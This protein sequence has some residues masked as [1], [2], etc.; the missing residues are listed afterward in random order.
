MISLDSELR[1][2]ASLRSIQRY[3]L[4]SLVRYK[5]IK[6]ARLRTES[7]ELI[8]QRSNTNERRRLLKTLNH[9]KRFDS[10]EHHGI[11]A[12][13]VKTHQPYAMEKNCEHR[14]LTSSS[15]SLTIVGSDVATRDLHR[16]VNVDSFTFL[17]PKDLNV[18]LSLK[19]ASSNKLHADHTIAPLSPRSIA[20]A[21]ALKL[22]QGVND[23][24][25]NKMENHKE[26]LFHYGIAR[27]QRNEDCR[28]VAHRVSDSF[29]DEKNRRYQ[30][31]R[32]RVFNEM[33]LLHDRR[34]M[35]ESMMREQNKLR[36]K[37]GEIVPWQSEERCPIAV[38]E[39]RKIIKRVSPVKKTHYKSN[40]DNRSSIECTTIEAQIHHRLTS[41]QTDLLRIASIQ[42][43]ELAQME[44]TLQASQLQHQKDSDSFLALPRHL[45]PQF[46]VLFNKRRASKVFDPLLSAVYAFCRGNTS[47]SERVVEL[48]NII[49]C[50]CSISNIECGRFNFLLEEIIKNINCE[51]LPRINTTQL[52]SVLLRITNHPVGT[53]T[54]KALTDY[55]IQLLCFGRSTETVSQPKESSK[56]RDWSQDISFRGEYCNDS[57]SQGIC[58]SDKNLNYQKYNIGLK[59]ILNELIQ[60]ERLSRLEINQVVRLMQWIS[61]SKMKSKDQWKILLYHHDEGLSVLNGA[62]VK[63]E[64]LQD[65]VQTTGINDVSHHLLS[66][67]DSLRNLL[68]GILEIISFEEFQE[69]LDA[70][71]LLSL[72]ASIERLE[73]NQNDY[74]QLVGKR[75]G[76]KILN[77]L[78]RNALKQSP[79]LSLSVFVGVV[80][81]CMAVGCSDPVLEKLTSELCSRL[82]SAQFNARLQRRVNSLPMSVLDETFNNMKSSGDLVRDVS[83]YS[84]MRSF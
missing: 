37:N 42:I 51:L 60:K 9:S 25:R 82:L 66:L 36:P 84:D 61:F 55:E 43:P 26:P 32:N 56:D 72:L 18:R 2:C 30:A 40:P 75:V 6:L 19:K 78:G 81:L 20:L 31:S 27:G 17:E 15:S 11:Y 45:V 16:L 41:L 69:I 52:I 46:E 4:F 64:G 5:T 48:L 29:E 50:M 8:H 35:T 28:S 70:P 47:T 39:R 7:N 54:E 62:Q 10:I 57:E 44:S 34:R 13:D 33:D 14:S 73:L 23:L 22:N 80:C 58:P 12:D 49:D 65:Q 68:I 79:Q 38:A 24:E 1:L 59:M 74:R 77:A 71:S 63:P 53:I 76:M 83:I 3:C 21:G 67:K